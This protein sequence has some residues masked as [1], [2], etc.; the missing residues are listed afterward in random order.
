MAGV[1]VVHG[2]S[3]NSSGLPPV[4]LMARRS[5]V[6]CTAPLASW[7]EAESRLVAGQPS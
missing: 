3:V 6:R 1:A 2:P 4:G 7:I 5:A